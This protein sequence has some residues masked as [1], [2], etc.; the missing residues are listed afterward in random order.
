MTVMK[1]D[2]TLNANSVLGLNRLDK[3]MDSS[4]YNFLLLFKQG[5]S[6]DLS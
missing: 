2:V 6:D 3:C 4:R 1:G 5:C